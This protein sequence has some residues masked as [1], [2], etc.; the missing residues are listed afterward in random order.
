MTG[1]ATLRTVEH[2]GGL[3]VFERH[4]Q[5]EGRGLGAVAGRVGAQVDRAEAGAMLI[6]QPHRRADRDLRTAAVSVGAAHQG[7]AVPGASA[8]QHWAVAALLA[9]EPQ[10]LASPAGPAAFK[11]EVARPQAGLQGPHRAP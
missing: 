1:S 4:A 3:T 10:L 11:G 7:F 8:D 9:G 2:P 5:P 6:E